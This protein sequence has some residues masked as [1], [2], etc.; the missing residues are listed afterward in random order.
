MVLT[1]EMEQ[2]CHFIQ[3]VLRF[4]FGGTEI[5]G[6]WGLVIF[7]QVN[8]FRTCGYRTARRNRKKVIVQKIW[9]VWHHWKIPVHSW[10]FW[11]IIKTTNFH[12]SVLLNF[13]ISCKMDKKRACTKLL[14]WQTENVFK[15]NVKKKLRV[16]WRFFVVMWALVY[17][18]LFKH[19]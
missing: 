13:I 2:T 5:V 12:E 6:F 4:S 19:L 16:F 1:S 3:M 10:R 11:W 14:L 17:F 8:N 7:T 18:G 15:K 9:H